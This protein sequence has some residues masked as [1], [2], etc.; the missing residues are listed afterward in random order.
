M[1]A[2]ALK[3]INLLSYKDIDIPRPHVFVNLPL[4]S[5]VSPVELTDITLKINELLPQLAD[6]ISQFHS[7]ILTNNINVITDA[8]GNMSLD[9]PGTMSDPHYSLCVFH[10]NG[11]LEG[12][13]EVRMIMRSLTLR[14]SWA[15]GNLFRS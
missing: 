4:K 5:T 7:I 3:L 2:K 10:L 9:V 8:G 6:F 1:K 12:K 15:F 14:S 11:D 13:M